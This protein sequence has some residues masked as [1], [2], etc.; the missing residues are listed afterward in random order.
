MFIAINP[1]IAVVQQDGDTPYR[2][3]AMHEQRIQRVGIRFDDTQRLRL[4][5]DLKKLGEKPEA[6][7]VPDPPRRLH[8]DEGGH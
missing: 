2:I 6:P 3:Y 4:I 7:E 5:E 8:H 1:I